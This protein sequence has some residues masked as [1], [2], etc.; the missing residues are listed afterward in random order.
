MVQAIYCSGLQPIVLP[1]HRELVGEDGLVSIEPLEG[2][3]GVLE[4]CK[5]AQRGHRC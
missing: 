3:P 4:S 1:P 5:S 2:E